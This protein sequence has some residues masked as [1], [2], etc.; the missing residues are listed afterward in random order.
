VR[1]LS[2]HD[3]RYNELATDSSDEDEYKPPPPKAKSKP[4]PTPKVKASP[5]EI[6]TSTTRRMS[7]ITLGDM[8]DLEEIPAI[9]G[10]I[11]VIPN[12]KARASAIA[13]GG[14]DVTYIPQKGEVETV[15]KKKR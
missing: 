2:S 3:V 5:M 11:P 15:K 12:R 8:D 6:S 9:E 1:F 7:R 10:D 4:K 14:D 13:Q